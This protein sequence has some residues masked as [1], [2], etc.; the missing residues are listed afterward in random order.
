LVDFF[1]VKGLANRACEALAEPEK[2]APLRV[3]ARQR[4]VEELYLHTRCVPALLRLFEG[5]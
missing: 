1:D 5:S 2:F 3:A 4:V